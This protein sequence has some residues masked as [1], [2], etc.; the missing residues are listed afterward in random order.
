M[1]TYA[2]APYAA[3]ILRYADAARCRCRF[4]LFVCFSFL[5]SLFSLRYA[6]DCRLLADV[7]D[8]YALIAF[9]HFR[10]AMLIYLLRHVR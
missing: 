1:H 9:A 10:H 8:A 3:I 2:G 6:A 4:S 7:Y 5:F